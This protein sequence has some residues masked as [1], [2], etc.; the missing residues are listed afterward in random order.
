VSKIGCD[1]LS[2]T[3]RKYLRGPRGVGFLHVRLGLIEQLTPPFLDLHAARWTA[4]DRYEI[5][6]D[7]RRFENWE[8][9]VAGRLGMGAAVDY[10]IALGLDR[11]WSTV[12]IRAD[13]LRD[14]LRAIPGITV[15]D[16]GA[17][18][19]GIVTF[20]HDRV[21]AD[22]IKEGLHRERINTET[23]SVFSTR[24]DMEARGL[25]KLVRA[26][27]HYLTTEREIDTLVNTVEELVTE[28]HWVARS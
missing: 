28:T 27:V 18:K 26:S 3:S 1:V 14:R 22:E 6:A 9:F 13:Q 21:G 12:Q 16:L 8:S 4:Q 23:S 24:F 19:G 5:R 20:A 15:H 11:V 25:T 10:A 17:T 2:A 7:A